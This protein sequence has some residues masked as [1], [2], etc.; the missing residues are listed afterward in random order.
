MTQRRQRQGRTGI[1]PRDLGRCGRKAIEE[2]RRARRGKSP[3]SVTRATDRAKEQVAQFNGHAKLLG[4][5]ERLT[6]VTEAK[7]VVRE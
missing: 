3:E 5:R 1:R 2:A 6:F 7:V 4:L